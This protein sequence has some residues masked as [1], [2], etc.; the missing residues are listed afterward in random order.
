MALSG[1]RPRLHPLPHPC[2]CP[3]PR[4]AALGWPRPCRGRRARLSRELAAQDLARE[5]E[6]LG[7]LKLELRALVVEKPAHG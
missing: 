1:P 4:A 6:A 7:A 2:P 3:C 5:R